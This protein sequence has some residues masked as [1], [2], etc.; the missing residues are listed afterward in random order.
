MMS[1]ISRALQPAAELA[2]V[3][4]V[5]FSCLAWTLWPGATEGPLHAYVISAC[6]SQDEISCM[7]AVLLAKFDELVIVF[8]LAF[9]LCAWLLRPREER[10]SKRRKARGASSRRCE[11]SEHVQNGESSPMPRADDMYGLGRRVSV[12][13]VS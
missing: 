13:K 1:S 3:F 9:V 10:P 2:A 4:I 8:A 6:A 12:A 5:S 7:Q 11:P